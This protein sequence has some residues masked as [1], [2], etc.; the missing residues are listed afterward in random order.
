LSRSFSDEESESRVIY[1]EDNNGEE[2]NKSI[3]K[4]ELSINLKHPSLSS[5]SSLSLSPSPVLFFDEL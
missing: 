2:S 5:F 4:K 3:F 1:E